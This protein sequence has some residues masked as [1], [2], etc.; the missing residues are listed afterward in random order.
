MNKRRQAQPATVSDKTART[1]NA[2]AAPN[3]IMART[4]ALLGLAAFLLTARAEP[5]DPMNSQ[6]CAAARQQLDAASADQEAP[7]QE[8][9]R[10]LAAASRQVLQ[11]C[12]GSTGGVGVRSGAPQP[13]QVVPPVTSVAPT[14]PLPAV[15]LPAP[16][17]AIPRAATLTHCDAGG[18]W[19]SEGRRLNHAGP[20]LMGPQ[21]LCSIQGGA[22][23]CPR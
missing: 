13:A 9:S 5:A 8:R 7:A 4:I 2:L 15:S 21:G 20:L 3:L 12:L 23:H 17:L 22:V 18:C 11:V 6:A 19:D 14:A 1:V 16:P 10:R